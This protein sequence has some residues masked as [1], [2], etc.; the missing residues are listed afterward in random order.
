MKSTH[1]FA[2]CALAFGITLCGPPAKGGDY[3]VNL[4][5]LRSYQAYW[6]FVDAF[7][8]SRPWQAAAAGTTQDSSVD[9]P[10]GPNQYPLQIPYDPDGAGP[11]RPQVVRAAVFEHNGARFPGGVY[12]LILDGSGTVSLSGSASGRFISPGT[13]SIPVTPEDAGIWVTIERS[14]AADPIR[15]IRLIMPGFADS[16]ERKTFHPE[17]LARLAGVKVIRF[18]QW[19]NTINS[20]MRSWNER[21]TVDHQTQGGSAGVAFEHMID[22][23]NEAGIDPWFSI[24]HLADDDYVRSLARLVRDRMLPGRKVWIE[25]SCEIWNWLWTE[26]HYASE[27]GLALGLSTNAEHAYLLFN[28]RRSGEIWAIFEE[29]LGPESDRLVKVIAGH[30]TRSWTGRVLLEGL[31]DPAVN[32]TGVTADA[33]AIAPYFGNKV[34]KQIEEA[35]T[36]ATVTVD[37][38]LDMCEAAVL[39]ETAERSRLNQAVAD[40]FGVRLVAYECGNHLYAPKNA[41]LTAKFLQ[42]TRHPRMEDLYRKMFDAWA[43]NAGDLMVVYKLVGLPSSVG[44][45]AL[46]EYLR[47]PTST[48]PMYRAFDEALRANPDD[49]RPPPPVPPSGVRVVG[50]GA[51]GEK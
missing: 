12:T 4:D 17:F 36:E 44:A 24:P 23:C 21:T 48:A 19:M 51:G 15:R 38:I 49:P 11:I 8:Q 2:V 42:A 29:E 25:Y 46:L 28:S 33:Y 5:I 31:E 1:G 35:G 34:G 22:L 40:S 32:P 14:V 7:K 26:T 30:A 20:T 43:T 41:A 37:E 39:S 47:Q 13:Y 45:M 50:P 9:V 18:I 6:A 3:G 27:R 10:M 16:H